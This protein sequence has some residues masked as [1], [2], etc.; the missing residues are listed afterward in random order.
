MIDMKGYLDED[1]FVKPVCG[2]EVDTT[3]SRKSS[4][5]HI[6]AFLEKLLPYLK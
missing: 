5:L 3:I 6:Y 4:T 2:F 1:C